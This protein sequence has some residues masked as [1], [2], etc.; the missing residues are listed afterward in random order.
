[1]NSSINKFSLLFIFTF[2][3][4]TLIAQEIA[5]TESGDTVYLYSNGMWTYDLEDPENVILEEEV[6]L[7]NTYSVMDSTNTIYTVPTN[8]NKKIDN[9]GKPYTL[10]YD[11]GKW[12]RVPTET[13]N[14]ES[15]FSFMSKKEDAF[16]MVIFEEAEI[17]LTAIMNIAM[18]NISTNIGVEPDLLNSDYVIVNGKQMIHATYGVDMQGI[19][20]IFDSFYYSGIEGTYQYTTWTYANMHKKYQEDLLNLLAGFTIR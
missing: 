15:D 11:V 2:F 6:S 13:M 19:N 16:A 14:A 10:A 17:G 9:K 1:M 20:F 7:F 8:N 4:F 12:K 5:V 3:C 18:S